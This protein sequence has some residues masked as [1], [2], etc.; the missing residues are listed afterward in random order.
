MTFLS[1]STQLHK[2]ENFSLRLT[3]V[4]H[5]PPNSDISSQYYLSLGLHV[6]YV[7]I[8]HWDGM[9][10]NIIT[11]QAHMGIASDPDKEI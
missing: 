7:L 4:Q 6:R 9:T 3:N 8:Y 5:T 2:L 10:K 1:F 11:E